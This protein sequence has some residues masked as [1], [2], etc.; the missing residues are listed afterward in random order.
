MQEANI[1][2]WERDKLPF[3][4]QGERLLAVYG[5]WINAE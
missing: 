5:Y 3:I 2:P 1:P 4:Y